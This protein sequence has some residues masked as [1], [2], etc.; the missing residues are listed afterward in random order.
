MPELG[1]A[2]PLQLHPQIFY[3]VD[4]PSL[5]LDNHHSFL[6]TRNALVLVPTFFADPGVQASWCMPLRAAH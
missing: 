1:I 2:E 3:S 4:I 6:A 5:M